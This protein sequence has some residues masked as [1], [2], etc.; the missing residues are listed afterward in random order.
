VGEFDGIGEVVAERPYEAER[1]LADAITEALGRRSAAVGRLSYARTSVAFHV[2]GGNNPCTLLLDRR[3]P[4]L[5]G[6]NEPAEIELHLTPRQAHR[7]ALGRLPRPNAVLSRAVS[8]RGPVRRYLEVDPIL[9]NLLAT[10]PGAEQANASSMNG[11]S[12]DPVGPMPDPELLSIE[13]RNLQK[14]FGHH[15]VL[16][17]ANLKVPEGVV[18]VVLGPSGTGKSV[19]LSHPVAADRDRHHVPRRRSVLDDEP[20]R[21]RRVP[22][23]SA[24]EPW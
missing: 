3:P 2:E 22:A 15:E 18:S 11:Y 23:A 5:T 24:H 6:G 21:Q 4:T 7:L 17:G 16:K 13:T 10:R 19:L 8:S 20:V 9:Q 14:R 12:H 1:A